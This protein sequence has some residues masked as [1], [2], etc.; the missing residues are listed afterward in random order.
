MLRSHL[1]IAYR[2]LL[3]FKFLSILNIIGLAVGMSTSLLLILF[4]KFEISYDRFHEDRDRIFRITTE[5]HSRDGQILYIPS[6]LGWMPEEINRAGFSDIVACRV[7][8][9]QIGS[10]YRNPWQGQ[11]SF[12]YADSTFFEV[13]GFKLLAGDPENILDEPNEVVLTHSVARRNFKEENPINRKF[14]IQNK[15]YKVC[16]VMEDVPGNSH[17]QFDLLVS[18]RSYLS[19]YDIR[20]MSLD[21]PVYLKFSKDVNEAYK[22]KLISFI[23]N[24][25]RDHYP[26]AGL[27][28]ESGLQSLKDI[29]IRSSHLSH[30]LGQPADINDLFILSSLALFIFLITLSNFV[31][32]LTANN[33]IR[34]R[35]IGM[36]IILG[37]RKDQI[38]YQLIC[39]SV[40]V[41]IFSAFIATVL[42]EIILGPFSRI[43]DGT[44]N[45]SIPSLA[46]FFVI[47]IIVAV[48]SGFLTGWIH[49]L[50]ITR[51]SP[52][53]MISGLHITLGR[54]RLKIILV[55]V[56]FGIIIFLFSVLS[57]LIF[58]TRFMKK[59]D[60]GFERDNLYIF[61]EPYELIRKDFAPIREKIAGLPGIVSVTASAGIPGEIPAVQNVWIDGDQMQNAIMITENRVRQHFPETFRFQLADGE[62][63]TGHSI[64]DTGGF[65]LNESACKALGVSHPV[66]SVIHVWDHRDTVIGVVKD[67]HFLSWHS[68][69]EPLVISRYYHPYRYITIRAESDTI[70]GLLDHVHLLLGKYF[71][72]NSFVMYPFGKLIDQMYLDEDRYAMLF[73]GGAM[74]AILI[75]IF[76]LIA[77]T[78]YTTIRRT[79]EVGIRKAMGGS[80][81][82]IFLFVGG[83][84]IRW[85]LISALIT[86]PLAWFAIHD[87]LQRY[88]YHIRYSWILILL[89][90]FIAIALAIITTSH[91]IQKI[92]RKNPVDSLRYE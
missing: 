26:E 27:K 54:D 29:H 76:G 50:S 20:K 22:S 35:D 18:F 5:I 41:G 12:Y 1:K 82:D 6:C 47:F 84:I 24:L 69:I 59:G 28:L 48:L 49:F 32:L 43:V 90:V 55:I 62:F 52:A 23:Q 64:N 63:F 89:S 72:D 45:L 51:F 19:M 65:I 36:R 73:F 46:G 7:F 34:V 57:V 81:G 40:L 8:N 16:G 75:G 17:L 60:Y 31:N 14:E 68:K 37:A 85:I 39:E 30:T 87:W 3:H 42:L 91:H 88:F 80:P 67:F 4:V 56:Q 15:F 74:L 70:K 78:T 9:D 11:L 44:L 79:K 33:N 77:L 38:L 10:K 2:N 61:Y 92:T 83:S 66:G 86:A 21:F 25:H 53:K 13:F 58:Q 71:P